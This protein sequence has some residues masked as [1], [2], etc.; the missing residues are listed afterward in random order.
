MV[1]LHG[2]FL[3][4]AKFWLDSLNETDQS[5]D[6]SEDGSWGTKV[7]ERELDSSGSG[8][9]PVAGFC[10]NCTDLSRSI[11]WGDFFAIEIYN[12]PLKDCC[13]ELVA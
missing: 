7:E 4:L 12:L 10:E 3:S 8:Q 1:Q 5:E 13:T 6:L 11:K 2:R 9:V